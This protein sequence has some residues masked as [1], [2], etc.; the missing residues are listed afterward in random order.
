M[1]GEVQVWCTPLDFPKAF[2]SLLGLTSKMSWQKKPHWH[3]IVICV[4]CNLLQTLWGFT[5]TPQ[6][7]PEEQQP[8][9]SINQMAPTT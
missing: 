3:L 4:M 5:P 6:K 9:A 1:S 8:K 2:Q 7:Y